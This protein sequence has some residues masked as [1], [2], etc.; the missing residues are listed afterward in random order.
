VLHDIRPDRAKGGQIKGS[1]FHHGHW[2]LANYKVPIQLSFWVFRPCG[3]ASCDL[4]KDLLAQS[5]RS[6]NTAHMCYSQWFRIYIYIYIYIAT[7]RNMIIW[8]EFLMKR[9]LFTAKFSYGFLAEQLRVSR[10]RFKWRSSRVKVKLLQPQ[11]NSSSQCT[12]MLSKKSK[13]IPL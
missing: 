1:R 10:S 9:S 6:T 11:A 4:L 7:Y 8:Q 2:S 13:T 3:P 5:Y 12:R